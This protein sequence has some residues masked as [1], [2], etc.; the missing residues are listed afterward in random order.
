VLAIGGV[1]NALSQLSGHRVDLLPHDALVVTWEPINPNSR[2]YFCPTRTGIIG[3]AEVCRLTPD[4]SG[5]KK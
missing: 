3:S 5:A 1:G 4:I 2:G